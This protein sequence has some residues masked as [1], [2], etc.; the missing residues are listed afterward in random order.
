[1]SDTVLNS[2]AV[3]ASFKADNSCSRPQAFPEGSAHG[4]TGQAVAVGDLFEIPQ[5][6]GCREKL[7]V[8]RNPS[9]YQAVVVA[10]LKTL[11]RS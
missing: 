1:M 10:L 9:M 4:A 6:S 7:C 3:Q 11:G 8:K 2:Q 5:I